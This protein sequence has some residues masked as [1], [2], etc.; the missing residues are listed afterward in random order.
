VEQW[1]GIRFGMAAYYTNPAT[2]TATDGKSHQFNKI[3]PL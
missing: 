1:I 2:G 3:K